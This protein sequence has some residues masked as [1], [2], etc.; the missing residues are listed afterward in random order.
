M[1]TKVEFFPVHAMMAN[2]AWRYNSTY[3]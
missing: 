1:R 2:V 3:Y